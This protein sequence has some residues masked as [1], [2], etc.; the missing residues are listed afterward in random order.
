MNNQIKEQEIVMNEVLA[1]ASETGPH[2]VLVKVRK[3]D[4]PEYFKKYY[5]NNRQK[6]LSKAKT[7]IKCP[8]CQKVVSTGHLKRHKLSR[9]HLK[10]IEP[11]V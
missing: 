10:A 8:D 2:S 9:D 1:L 7:L 6:F 3:T 11:L 4:D 5:T